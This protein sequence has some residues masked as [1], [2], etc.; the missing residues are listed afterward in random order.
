M[1]KTVTRIVMLML[2]LG[3]LMSS[4]IAAGSDETVTRID[5]EDGSYMTITTTTYASVSRASTRYAEKKYTYTDNQG[6]KV[7]TYLLKGWFTYDNVTSEAT[8][9]NASAVI[10][11]SGWDVS[12]HSEYCSGNT[13]YGNVTFK[14]P[15][16]VTRSI[17]AT[18]T[19][20]RYGN[21]D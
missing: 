2:C 4:A 16:F 17:N 15:L 10:H 6:D 8:D 20:D 18:L 1:K 14:G 12:S 3:M 9:V 5:Y 13:A 11:K 7:Y 19:C 21:I